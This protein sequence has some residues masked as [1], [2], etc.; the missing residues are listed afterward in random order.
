MKINRINTLVAMLLAVATVT[1][2]VSCG[3]SKKD[4]V[5]EALAAVDAKAKALTDTGLKQVRNELPRCP[6]AKDQIKDFIKNNVDD[7]KASNTLKTYI[8]NMEAS[9]NSVSDNTAKEFFKAVISY[10]KAVK[11]K[12]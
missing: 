11:D 2:I 3:G 9:R 10:A 1:G 12:K 8:N 4:P 6:A 7:A 5:A